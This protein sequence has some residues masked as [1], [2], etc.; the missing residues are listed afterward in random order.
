MVQKIKSS[1]TQSSYKSFAFPGREVMTPYTSFIKSTVYNVNRSELAHDM[2]RTTSS[3]NVD[4]TPSTAYY[5]SNINSLGGSAMNTCLSQMDTDYKSRLYNVAYSRFIANLRNADKSEIGMVL[6]TMGQNVR[7]VQSTLS[8]A[9]KM[10][11]AYL[12]KQDYLRKKSRQEWG[13]NFLALKFGL[14]STAEDLYK[15]FQVLGSTP[16]TGWVVGRYRAKDLGRSPTKQNISGSVVYSRWVTSFKMRSALAAKVEIDNPNAFL[17]N[18]L[19]LVNPLAV[20]WD[21]IPWSWVA[22]MFVNASQMMRACSDFVGCR[23][24][25]PNFTWHY[26]DVVATSSAYTTDGYGGYGYCYEKG[27]VKRRTCY[28]NDGIPMPGISFRIPNFDIGLAA[29]TAA[30]LA[31][32]LPMVKVPPHLSR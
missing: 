12:N 27:E 22:G 30:L 10:I 9:S 15:A 19:G 5:G 20:A 25:A 7:T 21:L 28:P 24:Y 1:S 2:W 13:S 6:A 16:R 17:L 26:Y 4:C 31:Q 14:L 18:N 11:G 29:I 3:L 8:G 32:R 23:I